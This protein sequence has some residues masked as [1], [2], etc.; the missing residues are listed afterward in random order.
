M[1]EENINITEPARQ[2]LE[3]YSEEMVRKLLDAIVSEKSYPGLETVEVTAEDIRRYSANV[4][5]VKI[6]RGVRLS[7]FASTYLFLGILVVLGGIFLED[8]KEMSLNSPLRLSL[9][10][11]GAIMLFFGFILMAVIPQ[12]NKSEHS[13]NVVIHSY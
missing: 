1:K 11:A 7:I 3:K 8:L 4:R 5:Y 2:Q 10:I 9:I 12:R 6:G 13:N